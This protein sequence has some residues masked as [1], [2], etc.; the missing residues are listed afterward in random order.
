VLGAH[1]ANLLQ[2]AEFVAEY[3]D[4]HAEL[5][6]HCR[7][8]LQEYHR[9]QVTIA[10]EI[11]RELEA[12]RSELGGGVFAT[13]L[14]PDAT[15]GLA[16]QRR[17]ECTPA[18][19]QQIS[20]VS[21]Y[22]SRSTLTGIIADSGASCSVLDEGSAQRLVQAGAA[23]IFPLGEGD[24]TAIHGVGGQ[25]RTCGVCVA[26]LS[27]WCAEAG[28]GGWVDFQLMAFVLFGSSTLR[29][30]GNTFLQHYKAVIDVAGGRVGLNF[31]SS[32]AS[33]PVT[34]K[35]GDSGNVFS[36]AAARVD[37][38]RR[39]SAHPRRGARALE[40]IH[41]R[42]AAHVAAL[43]AGEAPLLFWKRESRCRA[44]ADTVIECEAPLL[45]DGLDIFG[46]PL[47]K[48]N[49]TFSWITSTPLV[50]HVGN[51]KVQDGKIRLF[52]RNPTAA[53][54]TITAGVALAH[55]DLGTAG[56]TEKFRPPVVPDLSVD[57]MLADMKF[58][59][60]S[61]SAAVLRNSTS[62]GQT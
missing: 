57:E 15:E 14:G 20:Y 53:P 31:D 38:R 41:A 30:I 56:H 16:A 22:G 43:E 12:V 24:L 19:L 11:E 25:R 60:S 42:S 4:D 35:R 6:A 54:I 28:A 29:I 62:G 52:V 39:A 9:R 59:N 49:D 45:H 8:G 27:Y 3:G 55:F 10:S 44:F 2:E 48:R 1:V 61:C 26:K 13:T 21:A 51:Y 37:P 50:L 40:Q 5:L 46:S 34:I 33:T 18:V 58:D 7:L 47:D 17:L 36:A 32:T 23:E